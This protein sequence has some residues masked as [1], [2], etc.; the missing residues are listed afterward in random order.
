MKNEYT[1]SNIRIRL[2]TKIIIL[3]VSLLVICMSL[4]SLLSYRSILITRHGIANSEMRRIS[5]LIA[6]VH[7]MNESPEWEF[8]QDY[9]KTIISLYSSANEPDYLDLLYVTVRDEKG[10]VRAKSIDYALSRNHR[11]QLNKATNSQIDIQG[12]PEGFDGESI[13][14]ANVERLRMPLR[15]NGMYR[16]EIEVGYFVK[17]MAMEERA[18]LLRNI[19]LLLILSGLG[20]IVTILIVNRIER[21]IREV[22]AG[23]EKVSGGDLGVR[24][25][26]YTQDET[27]LLARGFNEMVS[28]LERIGKEIEQKNITI[29]ESEQRYR[30]LTESS[31]DIV[32]I[33]DENLIIKYVNTNT[34]NLFN[35]DQADIDGTPLSEIFDSDE[36]RIYSE[37]ILEALKTG[38]PARFEGDVHSV[39]H[40]LS[41]DTLLV[42]LKDEKGIAHSVMGM[43]RDISERKKREEDIQKFMALVENSGDCIAM[44]S[45]DGGPIYINPS[46]EKLLGVNSKNSNNHTIYD[47]VSDE[48]RLK[49]KIVP[50]VLKHGMWQGEGSLKNID[51]LET[52]PAAISMFTVNSPGTEEPM[53]FATIIHDMREY[54]KV[55]HEKQALLRNLFQSQKMEAVGTLAG[56]IAHDFNNVLA[57]II[58]ITELAR[59]TLLPEDPI[60]EKFDKIHDMS[61]RAKALTL[62]LLYFARKDKLESAPASLNSIIK[63][64]AD[65]FTKG[66][67]HNIQVELSLDDYLPL[68]DVDTNQIHQALLNIL[69]N[70]ADALPDNGKITIETKL[71]YIDGDDLSKYK[72]LKPGEYCSVAIRDN[73][74]GIE[75]DRLEKIFEPFFT[76]KEKGHG[77]G[78]GLFVTLGIIRKHNGSIIVDSEAG[79]FTEFTILIPSTDKKPAEVPEAENI[80]TGNNETILLIDDNEEF[81]KTA[82]QMLRLI[83]YNPVCINSGMKAID[84]FEADPSRFDAVILDMIMPGLSGKDTFICLKEA[85]PKAR[86]FLC[87]GFSIDGEAEELMQNGA[88]GFLQKPFSINEIR[89]KL[90]AVFEIV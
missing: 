79:E 23:M 87:S 46:G 42:P 77:T 84:L 31:K 88:C 13:T 61:L 35:A 65:L 40:D 60:L 10:A 34:L 2:R 22:I 68:V 3:V 78:L 16:G 85:D 25:D 53:C 14:V 51:T 44:T 52:I 27:M 29:A 75:E 59:K 4:L 76:T 24:L 81:L 17:K 80:K 70:S 48:Q 45:L 36:Y 63:D 82:E 7:T 18:A 32:F 5:S 90:G 11:I 89:K 12:Q 56:G 19:T 62:K 38:K 21:P 20:I 15:V 67:K 74:T 71:K 66:L 41:L 49:D 1:S 33:I 55:E 47:F 57:V 72:D 83:G 64:A 9:I 28:D 6:T 30:T 69:L 86:I 50:Y 26:V 37:H 73:G 58:G 39:E 8:T 43:S 54:K